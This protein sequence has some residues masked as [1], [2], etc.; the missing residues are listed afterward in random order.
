MISFNDK[1]RE[2]TQ[3]SIVV[4]IAIAF[5]I[6]SLSAFFIDEIYQ[7]LHQYT[8]LPLTE[9]LTKIVFFWIAGTLWMTYRY[10]REAVKKQND[11]ENIISSISPDVLVVVDSDRT[12]KRCN[13][14]VK[15]MFGYEV[16][17][18]ISQKTDFLYFDRRSNAALKYEIH[19]ILEHEGFHLGFAT[20]KKNNG[21]LFPIEII[22]GNL[23]GQNGAVLLL[24]DIT[25][26][27]KEEEA[28]HKLETQLQRAQKMEALGTLAGGVA[29]DLNNVLS[30]MLGYPDLLLLKIPEDSPLKKPLLSIKDSAE[31]AA[32]IVN[33]LLT[34]ARRGVNV[35]EVVNLNTVIKQYLE[36]PEYHKLKSYHPEVEF[37]CNLHAD[38]LNITGS[39]VHLAKT[40]MNLISNAA[41]AMPSG[42]TIQLSTENQYLDEP[43]KGYDIIKPGE[44]AVLTI[45]DSGI[46]ISPDN[47]SQIFEP[48]YT[49]KV[50]GRSGTG[51]GMSVV[52]GTVQDH[53]GYIDVDSTV[54]KGTTFKLY[55]PITRKEIAAKKEPQ[56]IEHYAGKGEH[57]LVVDDVAS[58]LELVSNMLQEL[59]YT[60]ATVS[61]GEQAVGYIKSKPVD[62]AVLDMI[63]EPGIDGLE[64]FQKILEIRPGQKAIIASGFAETERVKEAQKLGA[65]A[66]IKKPYT[67]EKIG[68]AVKQTL[69]E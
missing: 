52:W 58:Q 35:T 2:R 49:K 33:D 64:T 8:R 68:L 56:L 37:E 34:L 48:F 6:F 15:R 45:Q 4:V 60:V 53:N 38:L 63:M 36:T 47:L 3:I 59:H 27:K 25:E 62:L 18:V 61:S 12:I 41:E 1:N 5:A 67:L 43:V 21:D 65:S 50:M 54:G 69:A 66:F 19:E 7:F 39:P 28:R 51:L 9:L 26:R 55:F 57:I 42:G 44:Y 32:S 20:A 23:Q 31:K 22:S 30:A 24:R 29:H 17:E 13:P 10:W 14:S 40:V 46:G 11:L 16:Q